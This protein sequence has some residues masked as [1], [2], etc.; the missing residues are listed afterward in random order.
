M[1]FVL[2]EKH[3]IEVFFHWVALCFQEIMYVK[4]LSSSFEDLLLNEKQKNRQSGTAC[5]LLLFLL[6]IV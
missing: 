3:C 1:G 4:K 6:R 5:G 2:P